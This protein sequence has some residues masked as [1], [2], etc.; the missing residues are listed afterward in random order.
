MAISD[1]TSVH[2]QHVFDVNC[3]ICT[4]KSSD[5]IA[6][7][8]SD[9]RAKKTSD[10]RAKESSDLCAKESSDL[11][12]KKS[13]DLRAKENSSRLSQD[14]SSDS[15]DISAVKETN[16][17]TEADVAQGS[18]SVKE[19]AEEIDADCI[20]IPAKVLYRDESLVNGEG[21]PP[22]LTTSP[23]II[24][25]NSPGPGSDL[26]D[27][28]DRTRVIPRTTS[29]VRIKRYSSL[30]SD[31]KLAPVFTLKSEISNDIEG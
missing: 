15:H 30:P 16:P 18:I 19:E 24:P 22:W 28:R 14:S 13:S 8:S 9:L 23:I 31:T 3:R 20:E 4:G 26:T 1:T 12:A 6:K 25:K 27:P 29:L 2:G 5:L 21:V 17:V 10:L 7:K 11:R